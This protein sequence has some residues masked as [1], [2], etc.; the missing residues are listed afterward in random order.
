MLP[1]SLDLSEHPTAKIT[2]NRFDPSIGW[3]L[4]FNGILFYSL[5]LYFST[6]EA[7]WR[8]FLKGVDKERRNLQ[9][10]ADQNMAGDDDEYLAALD[11]EDRARAESLAEVLADGKLIRDFVGV[12][13]GPGFAKMF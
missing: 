10:I 8:D 2:R 9:A 6:R 7:A 4:E 1:R 5:R 13:K 12:L 3:G 11:A